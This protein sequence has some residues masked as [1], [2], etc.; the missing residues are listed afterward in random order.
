MA[1][2]TFDIAIVGGGVSGVYCAWRLKQTYPGKKIAVFEASNHIGGR[3]L[4]VRPPDIFDM[5]AELGGMRILPAVQPLVTQLIHELNKELPD[6]EQITLYDFPVDEPQNIAFLRGV[7]LRVADFTQN[8]DLVPYQLN[9][10]DHGQSAGAVIVN[11]IEQIVPGIT[12]PAL[13]E[14]QRREMAQSAEFGG[15]PL[16]KQGFWNVLLRVITGEAYQY[17]EDVGG[18]DS[19]LCNWNAADAIPWYLSDFGVDPKYKGFCKGFQQVP[20]SLAQLFEQAGGEVRL[21]SHV[22]DIAL[23]GDGFSFLVNG[24]AAAAKTLILAMPRRSLELL[25][26]TSPALQ[27]AKTQALI[28]TVTPRPLFKLFTTYDSPWWRNTGCTVSG[29]DGKPVYAA[30]EAGRS[31]TDLPVRQTYYWPKDNGKP[32]TSGHAMLLASYDDGDNTGFWDGLRAKRRQPRAR[33]LDVAPLAD[34]FIGV[35]DDVMRNELEW[36]QYKAP[37]MMTEEVTRQLTVMHSLSYTPKVRNAAYRDWGDDPFGGGW[38]SWNIGVKSW[39]V[40]H[41]V[42]QPTDLPL[43]IC[44]EAYSDAQGWVEGALQTAGYLLGKLGVSAFPR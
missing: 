19:T 36:H 20:L 22:S 29:T 37:R 15:V 35:D 28:S 11:A 27:D 31:V 5:V 10:I 34:P 40:K 23:K 3:L 43:Y 39:E 2:E 32:A 25:T 17:A 42:V 8:P 13:T 18:Y 7:Y 14:E 6:D 44:G 33:G 26:A 30:V 9:F 1:E 38:N 4:S 12:N 24:S 16:Y 21:A 41:A